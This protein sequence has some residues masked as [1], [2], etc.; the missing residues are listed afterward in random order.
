MMEFN[1]GAFCSRTEGFLMTEEKG[2]AAS[3]KKNILII[4]I[5]SDGSKVIV[6]YFA[7]FQFRI[8]MLSCQRKKENEEE[9][10][11]LFLFSKKFTRC[12][13]SVLY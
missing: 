6:F 2:T 8:T 7:L 10:F 9:K 1:R 3:A 12:T 4:F 5:E 13:M 11:V